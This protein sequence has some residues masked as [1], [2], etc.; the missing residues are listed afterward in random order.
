MIVYSPLDGDALTS[1]IKAQPR[2]CFLMTRLGRPIPKEIE[3]IRHSITMGCTHNNYTV[4]D[5]TSTVSGRDFL[6]K[7]WRMIASVPLSVGICHEAMPLETQGNI[8]YELGVAQAMGKETLLVKSKAARVPSDFVRTEYIEFN[9]QFSKNFET[10]F[11]YLND[12][13]DH[14]E[15]VAM[16]LENNPVLALDY[17]KRAYLIT[18]DN[19]LR[20]LA[21]TLLRAAGLESRALNSVELLAATF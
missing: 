14:Y 16:Q 7:I 12:Q 3:H 5:A 13:A 1:A 11:A 2:H 4:L 21:G 6:M 8:F 19:R 9:D 15:M 20:D 18:G 17:L 10:Y